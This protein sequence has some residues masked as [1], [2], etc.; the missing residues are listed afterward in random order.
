MTVHPSRHQRIWL[1][2]LFLLLLWPVAMLIDGWRWALFVPCWLVALVL[3]WRT[4]PRDAFMLEWDGRWLS[5]Q[6]ARYQL[7][8]GSRT[9]PGV[10]RLSLLPEQGAPCILWICSDSL[11]P[12]HYR[13]L[14]RAIHFLSSDSGR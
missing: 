13:L 8:P 9:L 12:A 3:G 6:G 4:L 1:L 10:L 5:W 11:P 7:G 2:A 14:A